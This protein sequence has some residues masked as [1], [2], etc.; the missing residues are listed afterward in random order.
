MPTGLIELVR[1]KGTS[2][3]SGCYPVIKTAPVALW[4]AQ[5]RYLDDL[6]QVIKIPYTSSLPV[7]NF[8]RFGGRYWWIL[9]YDTSTD[10]ERSASVLVSYCPTAS[11]LEPG[12]QIYGAWSRTPTETSP[13]LQRQA[14][15]GPLK[16]TKTWVL[17]KLPEVAGNQYFWLQATIQETQA[18]S[19]STLTHRIGCFVSYKTNGDTHSTLAWTDGRQTYSYPSLAQVL[20][21]ADGVFGASPDSILDISISV[22]SPWQYE[23]GSAGTIWLVT[24]AGEPAEVTSRGK[25]YVYEID[26]S[27]TLLVHLVPFSG[28]P[29]PASLTTS[30]MASGSITLRTED[31][32]AIATYQPSMATA[33]NSLYVL[34]DLTGVYTYVVYGGYTSCIQ[35]GH[36]PWSGT[37]WDTYKAYS[38]AY[39]REAM[40][41]SI[42][43]A[44]RRQ[45]LAIAEASVNTLNSVAMGAMG[46]NPMSI[47]TGAVSGVAGLAIQ[48]WASG[49][50]LRISDAEARDTQ[51]LAERRAQGGPS[52]PYNTG[53]GLIYCAR[54]VKTPASLWLEVP[55]ALTDEIDANYTAWFGFP[56]DL[57]GP[58]NV[59][60][61]YLSGEIIS[62]SES[63]GPMLDR[64]IEVIRSGCRLKIIG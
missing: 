6:R 61:G 43:Y 44:H 26:K 48:S 58:I 2:L 63:D 42:D 17:P 36:L 56:S 24:D 49:E 37:S 50:E 19:T 57:V 15:G 20:E 5:G 54:N 35:E 53:Y 52:T 47:I 22:R 21:D 62:I 51:A 30:E 10:A 9:S 14:V 1:I 45:S 38:L 25:G 33:D 3:A 46:G 64:L 29:Q 39:D 60:N 8:M 28:S 16:H 23:T 11:L 4:R 32:A 27:S 34:S 59:T 12:Q 18:D 13:H 55:E 41:Q 31:T 7:A 40:E